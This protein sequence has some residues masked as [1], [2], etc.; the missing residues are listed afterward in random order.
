MLAD[1][2][3]VQRLPNGGNNC[4]PSGM[5]AWISPQK[6]ALRRPR[7]IC[8]LGAFTRAFADIDASGFASRPTVATEEIILGPNLMRGYVL[9]FG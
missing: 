8:T 2:L 3:L 5:D 9:V 7:V 4:N 6:T 1:L